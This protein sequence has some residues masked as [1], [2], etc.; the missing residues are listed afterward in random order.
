MD[1]PW[2]VRDFCGSLKL[3]GFRATDNMRKSFRYATRAARARI[4]GI[5]RHPWI[6]ED[7]ITLAHF[8]SVN[9]PQLFEGKPAMLVT[10]RDRVVAFR[11]MRAFTRLRG[12][13]NIGF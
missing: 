12:M 10:I 5:R 9:I 7:A 6:V 3:D 2:R 4:R 13:M 1:Q 11:V 8:R